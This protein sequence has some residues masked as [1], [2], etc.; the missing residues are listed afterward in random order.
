MISLA[1]SPFSPSL[2]EFN[3][4]GSARGEMHSRLSSNA[5]FFPCSPSG[6]NGSFGDT[7]ILQI[8]ISVSATLQPHLS[9]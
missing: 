9:G 8:G 2:T 7:L 1:F 3:S 6:R 4:N 5:K